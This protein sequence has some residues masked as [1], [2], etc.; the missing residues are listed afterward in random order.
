MMKRSKQIGHANHEKW[1]EQYS[2]RLSWPMSWLSVA[3]SLRRAAAV[4]WED[5]KKD[6]DKFL[7][8]ELEE[9][10]RSISHHCLMLLGLSI[11][12][13]LKGLCVSKF[14]AFN[15]NNKFKFTTHKLLV[16]CEKIDLSLSEEEQYLMEV[17]EQFVIWAG[18]F[19][20]P[21]EYTDLIPRYQ[22]NSGY[23]PL[24]SVSESDIKNSFNTI[25]RLAIELEE[26]IQGS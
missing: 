21:L 15:K 12:N 26:K 11:E 1:I 24:N 2:R 5:V 20:G 13:L 4:L 19:P 23:A 22:K 9:I 10:Q 17:L 7:N 6:N 16:L 18:K 25:D 3:L 14:G 8:D